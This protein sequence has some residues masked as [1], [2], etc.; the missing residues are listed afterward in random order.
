MTAP[1]AGGRSWI[2]DASLLLGVKLEHQSEYQA[3]AGTFH[4]KNHMPQWFEDRGYQS[5]PPR[6]GR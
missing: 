5:R 4:D 1:V 3:I 2:A 6:G